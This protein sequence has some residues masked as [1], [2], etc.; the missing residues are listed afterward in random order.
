V[1]KLTRT[2][3]I[4]WAVVAVTLVA[5]IVLTF[6]GLSVG[7]TEGN[8]VARYLMGVLGTLPAMAILKLLGLGLGIIGWQYLPAKA[9]LVV[10]IGLAVPWGTASVMNVVILTQLV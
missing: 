7:A 6:I 1:G 5:D 8:P 9:R 4:A 3:R 2:E 10:P